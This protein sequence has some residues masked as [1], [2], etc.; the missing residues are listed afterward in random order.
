MLSAQIAR[1]A[2][3]TRAFVDTTRAAGQGI[4]LGEH[5]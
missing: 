5:Y 3:T 2:C 4:R 1:M